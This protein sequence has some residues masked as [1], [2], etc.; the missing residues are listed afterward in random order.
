MDE[1]S[2][3]TKKPRAEFDAKYEKDK[4]EFDTELD[5][6]VNAM[7]REMQNENKRNDINLFILKTIGKQQVGSKTITEISSSLHPK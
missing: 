3:K 5:K 7:T 2:E 1:D 4:L 6:T